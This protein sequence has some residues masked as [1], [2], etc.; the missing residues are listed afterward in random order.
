M[1]NNFVP[2]TLSSSPVALNTLSSSKVSNSEQPTHPS[3]NI[4][5]QNRRNIRNSHRKEFIKSYKHSRN[6][7]TYDTVSQQETHSSQQSHHTMR[8]GAIV[9][10]LL[11][12][13]GL[14][15]NISVHEPNVVLRPGAHSAA[16]AALFL[17]PPVISSSTLRNVRL[18]FHQFIHWRNKDGESRSSHLNE[19]ILFTKYFSGE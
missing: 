19:V 6:F 7:V 10:D 1:V 9:V 15:H 2:P 8:G 14:L 16:P 17:S 18:D 11:S 4:G 3:I 5:E 13:F 12:A